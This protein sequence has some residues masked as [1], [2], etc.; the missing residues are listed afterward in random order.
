MRYRKHG[1]VKATSIIF[2]KQIALSVDKS[3]GSFCVFEDVS[4]D[5]LM[6]VFAHCDL[7]EWGRLSQVNK[8]FNSLLKYTMLYHRLA[9]KPDFIPSTKFLRS[10]FPKV[11]PYNPKQILQ[12]GKPVDL[13][14]AY[15]LRE[16]PVD[17]KD[18]DELCGRV[19]S[20]LR[21]KR[22]GV[23]EENPNIKILLKVKIKRFLDFK[24]VLQERRK[25]CFYDFDLK[26]INLAGLAE[27]QI[28]ALPEGLSV[29]GINLNFTYISA[30]NA[31]LLIA[32]LKPRG[33]VNLVTVDLSVL[34]EEQINALPEGLSVKNLNFDE[35]DLSA[36]N[37]MLLEQK[38]GTA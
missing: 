3:V 9:S 6:S 30:A 34:T 38:L 18:L 37:A 17:Q 15:E 26:C 2:H 20:R 7:S 13:P 8:K 11:D 19:I 33:D 31:M 10:F 22:E 35:T 16:D 14:I 29:Q 5:M 27:D 4:D 25:E 21:Y 12:L 1:Y 32:K 36:A 24:M 23:D 28:T